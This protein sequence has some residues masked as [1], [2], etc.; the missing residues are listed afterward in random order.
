MTGLKGYDAWKTTPPE[1]PPCLHQEC[2]IT[3]SKHLTFM[4]EEEIK[5]EGT[6]SCGLRVWRWWTPSGLE[7]DDN[8]PEPD[9]D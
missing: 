9:L 1:D 3:W 8:D 7:H 6:C 2:D 5:Q 4:G